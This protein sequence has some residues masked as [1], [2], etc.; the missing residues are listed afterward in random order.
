MATRLHD[1]AA[2]WWRTVRLR[3]L[4]AVDLLDLLLV[5]LLD[6]LLLLLLLDD[7][8]IRW[9]RRLDDRRIDGLRDRFGSVDGRRDVGMIYLRFVVEQLLE[10]VAALRRRRLR[11]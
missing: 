3:V 1:S 11:L 5:D 7:A 10:I 8:G 6:L 2:R 4:D 9:R